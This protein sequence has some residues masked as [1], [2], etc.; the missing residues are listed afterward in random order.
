MTHS[1]LCLPN[2]LRP[3]LP[4]TT[5]HAL[6]TSTIREQYPARL[7]PDLITL[8]FREEK[9]SWSSALCSFLHPRVTSPIL[10]PNILLCIP[11]SNTPGNYVLPP[12][13]RPRF[14]PM[15]NKAQNYSFD[16]FNPYVCTRRQQTGKQKINDS[17]E[18]NLLSNSTWMQWFVSAIP[19]YLNLPY[20][21]KS[22]YLY[23]AI[24]FCVLFFR[25]ET[26]AEYSPHFLLATATLQPEPTQ[27][28]SLDRLHISKNQKHCC[29]CHR[30]HWNR[31]DWNVI[32]PDCPAFQCSRWHRQ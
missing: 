32:S 19:K 16:C 22:A 8:L 29:S 6:R 30:L 28:N 25:R 17:M 5:S 18:F 27:H 23:A 15:Q 1:R 14:S 11:F 31:Y 26:C 12:R 2:G 13:G 4:T 10:R 20:F 24:S 7:I 3:R 21:Q 9:K